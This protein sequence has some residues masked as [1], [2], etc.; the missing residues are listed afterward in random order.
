MLL[1]CRYIDSFTL[2]SHAYVWIIALLPQIQSMRAQ[3][4]IIFIHLQI[5]ICNDS[6]ESTFNVN[7]HTKTSLIRVALTFIKSH[8]QDFKGISRTFH[9][10][11]LCQQPRKFKVFLADNGGI[12][13]KN[14]NKNRTKSKFSTLQCLIRIY[15]DQ[16]G[17]QN[18]K[19]C[20][21]T[22]GARQRKAN[23]G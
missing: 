3:E 17:S 1:Y 20:T 7:M 4:M 2:L 18:P 21:S 8:I 6:G 5:S 13:K 19:S 11:K 23:R 10:K 14:K 15:S 9:E 12:Y 22:T 16:L